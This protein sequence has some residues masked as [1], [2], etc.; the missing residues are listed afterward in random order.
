MATIPTDPPIPR[1]PNSDRRDA[2]NSPT[3]IHR[4]CG[5]N[6][7]ADIPSSMGTKPRRWRLFQRTRLSHGARTQIGGPPRPPPQQSTGD[8]AEIARLTS[9]PPWGQTLADGDYSNGPAYPTAPELRSEGRLDPPHNN[10]PGMR[11]KSPG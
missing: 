8:A 5:R 7:Q 10:P 6:R 4:G 11:P 9:L 1:R 2:S 3:T